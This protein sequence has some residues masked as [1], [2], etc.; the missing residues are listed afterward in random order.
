ML[1]QKGRRNS[2]EKWKDMKGPREKRTAG[3]KDWAFNDVRAGNC[4]KS[5]ALLYLKR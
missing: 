1:Q 2:A 3:N 4:S 5:N